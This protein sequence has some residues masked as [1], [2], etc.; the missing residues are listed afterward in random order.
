MEYISR[1][2]CKGSMYEVEVKAHVKNP[3]S[4][5]RRIRKISDYTESYT[6]KD[7]Y[8]TFAG[9]TGYQD[10]RFRLRL[11]KENTRGQVK[12][13]VTA[14]ERKCLSVVDA[15]LEHEF[16][17]D[18]PEAFRRFA[19]LFG[20]RVLIEK[21]KEIKKFRY[22]P[23]GVK[24]LPGVLSIELNRVKGLGWFVEVEAL[25]E[26]SSQMKGARRVVLDILDELDVPRDM[27]ESVP[28]TR[29]LYDKKH[30]K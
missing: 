20:F 14:K 3:A 9:T 13:V 10:E 22:R 25:V 2:P 26:K 29:L 16:Q 19:H 24:N 1:K 5:E 6:C 30:N 8:F 18:D 21:V 27:I 11:I 7:T 4:L 17:V 28:Y 15:N 23:H 12:A